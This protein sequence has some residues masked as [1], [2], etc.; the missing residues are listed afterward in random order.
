MVH[1]VDEEKPRCSYLQRWHS[2]PEQIQISGEQNRAWCY[3]DNDSENGATYPGKL[4][5]WY[6][7]MGITTEEDYANRGANKARK[8]F[9][10]AGW[11]VPSDGNG[12]H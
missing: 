6:A 12:R 10:P 2:I 9:A 7:V 5:N 3:Y 4:Y 1:K 8:Q 11:H